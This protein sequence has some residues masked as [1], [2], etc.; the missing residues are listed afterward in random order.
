MKNILDELNLE[1]G[2]NYK[3][4]VL[5]KY[6]DNDLL[7]KLL[8]MTYD[9]VK[10]TY[11]ITL[12]NIKYTPEL[13]RYKGHEFSLDEALRIL[14]SEYCTRKI[15][16]ND[17]KSELIHLLESMTKDDARIIG[18]VLGRD[19]KIGLGRT[20]INKVF[21]GLIVKPPYMR[22]GIYSE[23]T[24]KKVN[25]PA[26]T[27]EKC[28]G[29]YV[30]VIVESG[31]ITF[32][33]R[34]GE[35]GEFPEL[36]KQFKSVEPGVYIGEL[37]VHGET[38]RALANGIINS[39]EPDHS[40]IYLQLWDFIG[41]EEWS[42]PKDK[43]DKTPYGQRFRELRDNIKGT[44][45]VIVPTKAV[46]NIKEALTFTRE[47]MADGKEGAILKDQDNIFLD[48]TSPTQLKLKVSF[49][50]DVKIVGFTDGTPGTSREA[51]FGAIK[52]ETSDGQ[53]VGQVSGFTDAQ[54]TDFNGKREE[55]IG[56]IMT[57]EGNDITKSRSKDTYAISHPR[58]IEL[59][60]DKAVAD[61]LARALEQLESGKEVQ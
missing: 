20:L 13:T 54:L 55:L 47:L 16:G 56:T 2:K 24:V 12:K 30:A 31:A 35:E 1:N 25:F 10:Y 60:N 50:I 23:K 17:A 49:D 42:R 4:D 51:T 7:K 5:K 38:N 46:R 34:S 37:L 15:T 58:F 36:K 32:Q 44:S 8:A 57:I 61:T 45:L 21:K 53:L 29:R 41:L 6:S 14:K 27:Q 33:S 52:Y 39:S 19:L 59:R 22:C 18:L 48:H 3:M 43:E 28:D 26:F 40:R 9:K 11:G